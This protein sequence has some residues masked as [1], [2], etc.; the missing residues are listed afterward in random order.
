MID[1]KDVIRSANAL[2][3]ESFEEI[4]GTEKGFDCYVQNIKE[5]RNYYGMDSGIGEITY[6]IDFYG[7]SN[8]YEKNLKYVEDGLIKK[9]GVNFE[10][11]G[12]L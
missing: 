3:K 5:C 10:V 6:E 11:C 1:I 2:I 12:H 7:I 9:F 4:T 8:D